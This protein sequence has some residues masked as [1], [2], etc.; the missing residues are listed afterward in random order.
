MRCTLYG[1]LYST[2]ITELDL[3]NKNL[4]YIDPN[5]KYFINLKIVNFSKNK[6]TEICPEIY[7]LINLEE[8]HLSNNQIKNIPKEIGYFVKLEKL[9]LE[10]NHLKS[11]CTDN[12]IC[13]NN[14]CCSLGNLI[15]LKRFY[16][17]NNQIKSICYG[18]GNLIS[19]EEI[20][21]S[22]NQITTLCSK[23]NIC[24]NQCMLYNN[25]LTN[26]KS[27]FLGNNKI[28]IICPNIYKLLSLEQLYLYKN[29]IKTICNE[30][31]HHYCCISN[32]YN[33]KN[34][35]MADNQI[36]YICPKIGNLNNLVELYLNSN[37][38]KILCPEIG[39]L[40]NL[41]KLHI[42]FNQITF[43]PLE[44]TNLKKIYYFSYYNNPIENLLNPIINRFIKRIQNK[45]GNIQSLYENKEN[46]HSSSIQQSIKD[47]IYN[48]LKQVK[49]GNKIN[50][51]DDKILTVQTKEALIEYSKDN[52]IHSQLECTFEE[53]LQAVLLEI[54]NLPNDL[55]IEVKKRLNE[56]INDSICKCFVGRLTRLVNSLS[57]YSDKVSIKISSAEEIGNIIS[58]MKDKYDNIED[59]KFNVEKELF[60]RGYEKKVIHEWINYL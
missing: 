40:N 19:L 44:I 35:N 51:L 8:L 23:N 28:T 6:I 55:Q 16:L 41:R 37:Q 25:K 3:S 59:V 54:N 14:K 12:K 42:F 32:L 56:E 15:N 48:L 33:L 29:Q 22:D 30:N 43:I 50:Y 9:Y 52:E 4:T 58:I 34:L 21:I 53:V 31:E 57:G 36:K 18:L 11:I 2:D 39:N 45:G 24:G 27:L 47:S 13:N 20:D 26:I 49:N 10:Y 60:E 1:K 46:I 17:S 5:I 7:Y 38:I